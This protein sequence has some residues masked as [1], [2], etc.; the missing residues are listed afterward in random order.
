LS[1]RYSAIFA[2]ALSTA[3]GLGGLVL[4][5]AT[6]RAQIPLGSRPEETV[7][8]FMMQLTFAVVGVLVTL[9]RPENPIG[10]ALAGVALASSVEF[11]S[12]GYGLYALYGRQ[13]LPFA[14]IALWI[15][16]WAGVLLAPF[17][18]WI[19][20]TFP[21]GR[22]VRAR[23]AAGL[24]ALA[25]G[26]V[27]VIISFMFRPGPLLYLPGVVNPFGQPALARWLEL[28]GVVGA[29]LFAI[30]LVAGILTIR[31]RYVRA[32]GVE[33]QQIKWFLGGLVLLAIV[34]LP[35]LPFVLELA[36]D[37]PVRYAARLA[38]ALATAAI[39]VA[40]GVA[41]LRYR[42]YDIDLLINRTL[43]YGA[44]STVVVA[45]YAASGPAAAPPHPSRG[46]PPLLPLPL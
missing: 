11:A 27:L 10:W 7:G 28:V 41:I 46:G 4:L 29:A 39:P 2:L 36:G 23:A 20:F 42:L 31:D 1:A 17:A 32:R 15:Y 21:H 19:A 5:V 34:V 14:D 33:R 25:F 8:Y 35:A 22:L 37:P 30:A 26:A 38:T 3:L 12:I 40:I 24:T 16:S 6:P 13:T 44:T 43:V 9:R 45:A 18:A